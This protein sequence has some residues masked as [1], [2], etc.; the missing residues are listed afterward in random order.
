MNR[1]G[2]FAGTFDPIHDGHLEVARLSNEYLELNELLFM[3]E[4]EP[5]GNKNPSSA[6]HRQQ[7][8][9]LAIAN[10]RKLSQMHD[11]MSHFSIEKTLPK[12]EAKFP[13]SELYFIFGGDVFLNMNSGQWPALNK[14]LQHHIVVFERSGV[15]NQSI[16]Q[17]ARTLGIVVA[18]I[19]STHATHASSDVRMS[20]GDA[21]ILVP[22][23]VA[24]YIKK[25]SLYASSRGY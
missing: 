17:H 6:E 13:G 21:S 14:L 8:V 11:L 23:I 22:S 4:A 1:V 7:M 19:P 25:H 15:S 12:L 9:D 20:T 18:I 3:V 2:F 16:E 5:W 24:S 10:D